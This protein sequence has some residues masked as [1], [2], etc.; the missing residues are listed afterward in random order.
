MS[1]ARN[2]EGLLKNDFLQKLT[3]SAKQPEISVVVM[4]NWHVMEQF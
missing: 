1:V 3:L 2:A 4:L